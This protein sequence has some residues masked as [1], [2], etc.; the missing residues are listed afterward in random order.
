MKTLSIL[1][2]AKSSWSFP[3][4]ADFDRPLN[5]RGERAAPFMGQLIASQGLEPTLIISSPAVRAKQTALL[6]KNAGGLKSQLIFDDRIY[7]ASANGLMQ[8]I[9]GLDDSIDKAML[10][11]HNPGLEGLIGTLTGTQIRLPTAGLAVISLD[12]EWRSVGPSIGVIQAFY[13]PKEEM[14]A[15]QVS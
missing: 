4:V 6:A 10:V 12:S 5:H 13:R 8:V 15:V 9:F 14:E 11:G 7:E 2:H 3:D 1:R